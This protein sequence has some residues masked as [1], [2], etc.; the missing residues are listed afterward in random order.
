MATK[1][2]QLG[3]SAASRERAMNASRRSSAMAAKSL[4]KPR[5][6]RLSPSPSGTVLVKYEA[7]RRALR[8][9]TSVDD[10]KRI[11]NE[12]EAI[13][14]Y[15]R[16]A[17]DRTLEIDAAEIRIRAER[18][19][20]QMI[21]DQGRAGLLAK[22]AAQKGVGRLGKRGYA[23]DP[24]L[25][26][27][28]FAEL[29]IDKRLANEVR[30]LAKLS[31]NEFEALLVDWRGRVETISAPVTIKPLC[32][33]GRSRKHESPSESDQEQT[34][35]EQYKELTKFSHVRGGY[36]AH[37]TLEE[38][39]AR[40]EVEYAKA[41]ARYNNDFNIS[42]EEDRRKL[43]ELLRADAHA[44]AGAKVEDGFENI[45][46]IVVHALWFIHVSHLC[47][48]GVQR[49]VNIDGAFSELEERINVFWPR[50]AKPG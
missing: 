42:K 13:R 6:S 16:Q 50:F 15:A 49:K 46:A 7:A 34:L 18:R 23:R 3:Q 47:L 28:T 44:P 19:L 5:H 38:R 41:L 30:K 25:A 1:N 37:E 20:G 12:A 22:G 40:E 33:A 11:R 48:N 29:R 27:I 10:V 2:I 43:I 45:A 32:S 8:E 24:H 21:V 14:A 4:T 17:K 26:R 39:R 36:Y 35:G 9:A 31:Q